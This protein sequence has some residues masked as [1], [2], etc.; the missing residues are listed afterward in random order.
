LGRRI[1]CEQVHDY[2]HPDNPLYSE[3]IHETRVDGINPETDFWEGVG[4]LA[5]LTENIVKHP[6]TM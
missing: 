6:I 5:G 4:Y 1:I 2:L 3:K